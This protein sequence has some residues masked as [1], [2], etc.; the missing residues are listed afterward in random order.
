VN[1]T[2]RTQVLIARYDLAEKDYAPGDAE[3][4]VGQMRDLLKE[5]L[6]GQG[7]LK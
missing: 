4:Y 3:A 2:E 7:I 1:L 5:W 6:A